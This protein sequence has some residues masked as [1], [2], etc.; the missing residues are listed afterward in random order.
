MDAE[1]N[2]DYQHGKKILVPSPDVATFDLKPEMAAAEITDV[3]LD[4]LNK[5]DVIILNFANGDMVGHTGN[6][7]AAIKA[8]EFLDVQ[9]S[10]F[11]PAVLKMGGT[12]LITADHGNAE[13]MW[14][15]KN[16][17]VLTSHT[18]STVN[19]IVVSNNSYSVV[20]GG[21]ADVAP[22]VLKLL[23]IAQPDDMTGHSLVQ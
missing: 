15:Q 16:K 17:A 23:G 3:L 18:T 14:D 20:D 8:M 2:I 6:L 19:F 1:R 10:R 4:N 11:V 22:T 21:L 9:L 12:V 13:Q 7:K 5:F